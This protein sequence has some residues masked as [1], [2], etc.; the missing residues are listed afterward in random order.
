MSEDNEIIEKFNITNFIKKNKIKLS[1]IF[2]FFIIIIFSLI[3]FNEMKKKK[4]TSMS[5]KFNQ[6]KILIDNNKKKDALDDLIFIIEQ[7]ISFY[8]PSALN[9]I[10]E[11]NLITD[12][13][14][15]LLLF[16]KI[17]DKT[18]LDRETKNLFIIKKTFF[19]GDNITEANLLKNLNPIIKS[20]SIWK[21]TAS[22]YIKKFYISRKEFNKAKSFST[23][24]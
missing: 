22:D 24:N 23:N 11:K 21:N 14:Q 16:D 19:L 6:A 5:E 17:I 20:D 4:I 1:I 12:E 8:S 2:A 7:N 9:L 3:I 13:K 10:L 15:I 18:K